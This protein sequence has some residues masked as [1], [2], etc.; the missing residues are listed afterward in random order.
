MSDY[1]ELSGASIKV[2]RAAFAAALSEQ[3]EIDFATVKATQSESASDKEFLSFLDYSPMGYPMGDV[4]IPLAELYSNSGEDASS[5]DDSVEITNLDIQLDD[6]KAHLYD[7]LLNISPDFTSSVSLTTDYPILNRVY[8]DF[9]R[10][11]EFAGKVASDSSQLKAAEDFLFPVN[12]A[13]IPTQSDAYKRYVEYSDKCFDLELEIAEANS[14]GESSIVAM[15]K[16]KLQRIEAEWITLGQ[17][18]QVEEALETL[19]SSDARAGYEDERNGFS[20]LLES[21]LRTRLGSSE[22]YAAVT[23]SPLK[24]LL[25]P[26]DDGLWQKL[27]LKADDLKRYLTPENCQLFG[28]E[29]EELNYVIK[30]FKTASLEYIRVFLT[31]EW[32]SKTFLRARYWDNKD[33]VLSDGRGIGE[34]PTS[35]S[36]AF[37]IKSAALDMHQGVD[38]VDSNRLQKSDSNKKKVLVYTKVK[39]PLLKAIIQND[40]QELSVNTKRRAINVKALDKLKSVKQLQ[41]KEGLRLNQAR[42]VQ[43]SSKILH[44]KFNPVKANKK[45]ATA[46]VTSTKLKSK[47][48]VIKPIRALK[49]NPGVLIHRVKVKQDSKRLNISGS[50]KHNGVISSSE[51][52]LSIHL[53]DGNNNKMD[54]VDVP[55]RQSGAYLKFATKLVNTQH[56]KRSNQEPARFAEIVLL[57]SVGEEFIR[58]KLSFSTK[59]KN[60]SLNWA[61]EAGIVEMALSSRVTPTLFAYGLGLLPK[62]PNPDESLFGG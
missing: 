11:S 39:T 15:L 61:A 21:R 32:L 6:A 23:I 3:E 29:E 5:I 22:T 46:R 42:R 57:D 50:I 20:E 1:A 9:L 18:L 62:S 17:K 13:G 14:S 60:V 43:L 51:V 36:S 47:L 53:L 25:E 31:R 40:E 54:T 45:L 28:V 19:S 34:L 41:S 2:I 8:E 58:E 37:F 48:N 27:I 10:H 52:S 35:I 59:Q 38:I 33:A 30:H 44:K 7:K 4:L 12:E 49:L 26:E 55:I 16:K 56:I 24:P